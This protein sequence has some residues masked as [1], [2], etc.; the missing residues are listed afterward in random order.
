MCHVFDSLIA[1]NETSCYSVL[2]CKGTLKFNYVKSY[3]LQVK[4]DRHLLSCSDSFGVSSF[5]L[6]L[7]CDLQ[8][9]TGQSNRLLLLISDPR[10]VLET[11][12]E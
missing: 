10:L 1:D 6:P 8:L 11:I 9:S 7:T 2:F 5:L 4:D 3:K 12:D